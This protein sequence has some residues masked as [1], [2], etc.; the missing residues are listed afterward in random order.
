MGLPLQHH[1]HQAQAKMRMGRLV[2]AEVL[3]KRVL[4]LLPK[5]PLALSLMRKIQNFRLMKDLLAAEP[6]EEQKKALISLYESG[7]H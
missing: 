1:I 4:K 2:V 5:Q 3:C 6:P 7:E